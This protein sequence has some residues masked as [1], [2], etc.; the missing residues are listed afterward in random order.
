MNATKVEPS[1][2]GAYFADSGI[3]SGATTQAPSVTGKDEE[4][5]QEKIL[6]DM[7]Q[8]LNQGFTQEQ[9]DGMARF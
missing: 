4:T 6:Y 9:V 1:W 3:H 5:E 7:D 8:G 2:Q